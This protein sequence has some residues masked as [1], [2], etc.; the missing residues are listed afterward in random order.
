MWL[1]DCAFLAGDQLMADLLL[2]CPGLC[3]VPI[4]VHVYSLLGEG[5]VCSAFFI[6]YFYCLFFSI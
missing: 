5:Y 4:S 2:F 3:F 6:V 1:L